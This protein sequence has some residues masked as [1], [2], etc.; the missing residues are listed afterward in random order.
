[1][2]QDDF[3]RGSVSGKPG[4]L[5]SNARLHLILWGEYWQAKASEVT[6]NKVTSVLKELAK[7]KYVKD[8][9]AEYGIKAPPQFD[10]SWL[11]V[12][13]P[14]RFKD[15]PVKFKRRMESFPSDHDSSD[16]VRWIQKLLAPGGEGEALQPDSNALYMVVMA[17]GAAA[18]MRGT[19]GQ[20]GFFYWPLKGKTR[21]RIHYAWATGVPHFSRN[22]EAKQ[23]PRRKELYDNF[24][25]TLSEELLE[26]CTDPEPYSGWTRDRLEICDDA[27]K[28]HHASIKVDG[29]L[30]RAAAYCSRK[31]GVFLPL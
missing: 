24:V 14:K 27:E 17:P 20:H 3:T 15:E 8:A 11:V 13:G 21:R 6:R 26:A 19:L 28:V 10:G 1:M 22:S 4:K 16:V 29:E 31:G 12:R 25:E 18:T 30:V 9:L 5:L 7:S 2:K 23:D